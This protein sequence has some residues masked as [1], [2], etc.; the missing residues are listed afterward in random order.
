MAWHRIARKR[1]EACWRCWLF[2]HVLMAA[3]QVTTRH[4]QFL[5]RAAVGG[6]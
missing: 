1:C 5:A 3:L 4:L 2:S 6:V